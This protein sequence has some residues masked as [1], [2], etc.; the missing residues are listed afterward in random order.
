MVFFGAVGI[1]AMRMK[2][3]WTPYMCVFASVCL[4]K[5]E[6]WMWIVE[7]FNYSKKI[8]VSQSS[9]GMF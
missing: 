4:F 3:F 1:I 9:F 6:P 7:K 5:S 8:Q 2:Y